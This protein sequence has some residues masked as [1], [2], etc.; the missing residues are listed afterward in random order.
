MADGQDPVSTTVTTSPGY[1]AG[2]FTLGKDR[3]WQWAYS[4]LQK[5]KFEFD[6][7]GIRIDT[8]NQPPPSGPLEFSGEAF[9]KSKANEYWYGL[10]LSR[11]IRPNIGLGFHALRGPAYH[12]FPHPDRR[13]GA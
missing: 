13:P 6:A 3:T 1:L 4:Y 8:I 11:K 12:E 5:V 2:R 7:V 9:R 10:T